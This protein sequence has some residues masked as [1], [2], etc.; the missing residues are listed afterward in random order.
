MSAG[1][2]FRVSRCIF[3][4]ADG[5]GAGDRSEKQNKRGRGNVRSIV[6]DQQLRNFCFN[7]RWTKISEKMVILDDFWRKRN[8]EKCKI[9]CLKCLTS[10]VIGD[11]CLWFFCFNFKNFIFLLTKFLKIAATR[12][13]RKKIISVSVKGWKNAFKKRRNTTK[14]GKFEQWASHKNFEASAS[15]FVKGNNNWLRIIAA[16][17]NESC[18][19][20][21]RQSTVFF[22]SSKTFFC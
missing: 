5:R 6:R 21:R 20:G 1:E 22:F 3:S 11:V 19:P 14:I 9:N 2:Q 7:A 16:V 8:E 12:L 4:W 10:F 15:A 17:C 18:E 13:E